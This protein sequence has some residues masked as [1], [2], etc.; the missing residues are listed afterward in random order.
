MKKYLLKT[1]LLSSLCVPSVSWSVGETSEESDATKEEAKAEKGTTAADHQASE[2][3][4]AGM[5]L[6]KRV[7][8]LASLENF[9][10]SKTG[11][12]E[13]ASLA[14][15]FKALERTLATNKELKKERC[16]VL[17]SLTKGDLARSEFLPDLSFETGINGEWPYTHTIQ[18]TKDDS[19]KYSSQPG[20]EVRNPTS[21]L[22]AG[23]VLKQNLFNGG[24]SLAN[25]KATSHASKASFEAYKAKEDKAVFDIFI[26]LL[27]V[28]H[29]RLSMKQQEGNVL[30]YKEFLNAA[31]EKR[32]VG[33]IDRSEVALAESKLA[34]AEAQLSAIKIKLEGYVGD[35]ERWTGIKV[36]DL[37]L[38]FPDFAKYLPKDL[39]EIKNI[40]AKESH[41]LLA[42]HYSALAA[43]ASIK[44]AGREGLPHVDF[45][46]GL[47]G[48]HAN[49]DNLHKVGNEYK[50][51][52]E[53]EAT[54]NGLYAK[55]DTD[56]TS[57]SVGIRLVVPLDFRGAARANESSARHE[58]VK[59]TIEGAKTHGDLMSDLE[60]AFYTLVEQKKAIE[61]QKRY[62]K[63]NEI[64]FQVAMQEWAVGA[65][66]F[67]QALK[68]ESDLV[69]AKG[70]LLT[71]RRDYAETAI[72]ILGIMGR[73]NGKTFGIAT[74]DFNPHD[75][76]ANKVD[77]DD[78]SA[79]PLRVAHIA[80]SPASKESRHVPGAG[81]APRGVAATPP[82][83]VGMQPIIETPRRRGV[84]TQDQQV[85]ETPEQQTTTA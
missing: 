43:K 13:Q 36:N 9:G 63:A 22:S 54:V 16:D 4:E 84:V 65:K 32:K 15:F 77:P 34:R 62:V 47:R 18:K 44:V 76:K 48:S 35:L 55:T 83:K 23:L 78:V 20:N 50:E 52:Q 68:A 19:G 75:K 70:Y 58:Y 21:T 61:Y 14:L 80:E 5:A 33:D 37:V 59:T 25:R 24:V 3:T 38:V 41:A 12:E 72:R 60:T 57:A 45:D 46:A 66:V 74:Y 7:L 79:K 10:D 73:L 42:G 28:I 85:P 51:F 6:I 81:T 56:T 11:S 49:K 69:E 17:K 64:S 26:L 1:L 29:Q 71:A 40:A 2:A 31:L 8:T 27:N 67:T 39:G 30:I 82:R 53:Q